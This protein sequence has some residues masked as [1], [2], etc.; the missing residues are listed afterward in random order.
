M[1]SLDAN[2]SNPIK[3]V[4]FLRT[5]SNLETAQAQDKETCTLYVVK[6]YT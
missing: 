2:H 1:Q 6:S 3:E 4:Q 5:E